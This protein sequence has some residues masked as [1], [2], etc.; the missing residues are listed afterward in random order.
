MSFPY[1]IR[2][3]SAGQMVFPGFVQGGTA[4]GLTQRT[5]SS[6]EKTKAFG[7]TPNPVG[8]Y[9]LMYPSMDSNPGPLSSEKPHPA[10][11]RNS[12]STIRHRKW[13]PDLPPQLPSGLVPSIPSTGQNPACFPPPTPMAKLCATKLK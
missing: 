6:P 8:L 7:F 4:T 12:T 2:P 1:P 13:T 3:H 10:A 11:V 9:V 5:S